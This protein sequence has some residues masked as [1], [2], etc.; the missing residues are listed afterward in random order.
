[1]NIISDNSSS[2]YFLPVSLHTLPEESHLL[3]T[4]ENLHTILKESKLNADQRCDLILDQFLGLMQ[5][6]EEHFAENNCL[7]SLCMRNIKV[8]AVN[9]KIKFSLADFKMRK[10]TCFETNIAENNALSSLDL[11]GEYAEDALF[12]E[13][14]NVICRCLDDLRTGKINLAAFKKVYEKFLIATISLLTLTALQ[15]KICLGVSVSKDQITIDELALDRYELP[16]DY[17]QLLTVLLTSPLEERL[18]LSDFCNRLASISQNKKMERDKISRE[19]A[20]AFRVVEPVNKWIKPEEIRRLYHSQELPALIGELLIKKNQMVALARSD[21]NLALLNWKI[22]SGQESLF[23]SLLEQEKIEEFFTRKFVRAHIKNKV[24]FEKAVVRSEGREVRFYC[25]KQTLLGEGKYSKVLLAREVFLNGEKGKLVALKEPKLTNEKSITELINVKYFLN[26]IHQAGIVP[27]IEP[28]QPFLGIQET[29]YESTLDRLLLKI[30]RFS[31]EEQK[32][33]V[34]RGVLDLLKALEHFH[35]RKIQHLDIK[36]YNIGLKKISPNEFAFQLMDWGGVSNVLELVKEYVKDF[37]ENKIKN[38]HYFIFTHAGSYLM[39]EI[40]DKYREINAYGVGEQFLSETSGIFEA[41]ISVRERHD[42][43][44]F[45]I[46]ILE[47]LQKTRI[48][49]KHHQKYEQ[50]VP[51]IKWDSGIPLPIKFLN[52]LEEMLYPD[53]EISAKEA[54]EKLEAI[55]LLENI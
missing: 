39:Q 37:N 40:C 1:M 49:T 9:N 51:S 50:V 24:H 21:I 31:P 28:P 30:T 5:G 19:I 27:G 46:C 15:N 52:L 26:I 44:S 17:L 13:D 12:T 36:P 3:G 16:A 48:V 33:I 55:I 32:K 54:R 38:K 22:I 41:V 20:Q 4:F 35:G 14:K 25:K 10:F 8:V 11:L 53:S 23:F 43:T 7:S 29:V 34:L 45:A 47:C 2:A 6:V 18:G 42:I